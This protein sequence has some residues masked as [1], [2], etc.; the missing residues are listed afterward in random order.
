MDA[1]KT[2]KAYIMPRPWVRVLLAVMTLSMALCLVLGLLTLNGEEADAVVFHPVDSETGGMAYIDVVGVSDWLYQYDDATYYSVEDAEGYLY[3]VRLTERQY[4]AMAEQ[5]VFWNR[6]SD[7]EP[8]PAPYRLVGLVQGTPDNVRSSLAQSWDITP[9]QYDNYFGILLLNATTSANAQASSGWFLGA[10]FSGMF[11]L[12][13]CVFQFRA[14]GVA[15]K[16]LARLEETGMLEKAAMQLDNPVNQTVIGRNKAILTGDF[17][18]GKGTGAVLAYS[19]IIWCYQQDQR[20]NF[21]VA[22]SYLTA[23]TAF[24]APQGVID[25]N[26]P[27]KEGIIGDALT[28]IARKNP[29]VLVG[30]SR[31]NSREYRILAGAGK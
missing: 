22:N 23:G 3:T 30:Y 5:Q 24:L 11:A 18:F 15:K 21:M 20:R 4:N 16:C 14:A 25:L 29:E 9:A 6:E 17:L 12:L 7:S 8:M 27:D 2:I 10:L 31:E 13:C 1:K 19:D 26:R 28:V